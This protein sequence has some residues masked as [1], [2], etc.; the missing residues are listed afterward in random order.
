M[1]TA[2][3]LTVLFVAMTASGQG[4]GRLAERHLRISALHKAED[5][6]ATVKEVELQ[7][8][9]AVG[10]PWQDSIYRYTYTLGRA[11]WKS[12]SADAGVAATE[13]VLAL[14]K[15]LDKNVLH[16]LD[17]M[18]DVARLHFGTRKCRSSGVARHVN[19]LRWT[20]RTWATMNWP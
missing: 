18:D 12:E 20:T 7:L 6:V 3:S 5:H 15:G 11:L 2:L 13:R 19:G 14:V 4:S 1:R 17:A 10:T 8:K 16:Q 9:E